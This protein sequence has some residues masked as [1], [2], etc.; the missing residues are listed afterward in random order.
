[1]LSPLVGLDQAAILARIGDQSLEFVRLKPWVSA[2]I[3]QRIK[4]ARL[5]GIFL[6][7][8]THRVYPQG[9]LA[10]HILGFTNQDGTGQYGLEEAYDKVLGGTPGHL[11]AEVDTAGRPINFV[12]PR[13]ALPAQ[14][15]ASLVTT[16]DAT[17]QYIAQRE[18]AA[19]VIQHKAK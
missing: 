14:D 11:R 17:L 18:L 15:G 5:G 9:I 16:I 1:T 12:T 8:T 2:D 7:P 4:D 3:S 6:E 10:A 19:A 13:D